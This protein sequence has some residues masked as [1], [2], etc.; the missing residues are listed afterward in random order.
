MSK[1]AGVR[2]RWSTATPYTSFV[3]TVQYYLGGK[4]VGISTRNAYSSMPQPLLLAAGPVDRP[5]IPMAIE[6]DAIE[7]VGY[8]NQLP[9]TLEYRALDAAGAEAYPQPLV[10][11]LDPIRTWKSSGPMSLA[12]PQPAPTPQPFAPASIAAPPPPPPIP[13]K[14]SIGD[15][16]RNVSRPTVVG[17][18][19]RRVVNTPG[20]IGIGPRFYHVVQADGVM[21]SDIE[22]QWA[23]AQPLPVP[24]PTPEPVSRFRTLIP[25]LILGSLLLLAGRR[26]K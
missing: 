5:H 15:V 20:E 13:W 9:I 11:A 17:K 14:F 3:V 10:L 26:I 22:T 1:L 23:I 25:W 2:V 8:A 21:V 12:A 18:V 19:I 7:A 6:V 16:L 4:Q 24:V